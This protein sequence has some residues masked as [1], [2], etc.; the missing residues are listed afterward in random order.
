MKLV[1]LCLAVLAA[2]PIWAEE[3]PRAGLLGLWG[4][5]AHCSGTLLAP[6]GTVRAEPFEVLPGA[7]RHGALWCRLAWYPVVARGDGLFVSARAA[8]GEDA[9]RGYRLDFVLTGDRLTLI[10]DEKL[11]NGP[12]SRCAPRS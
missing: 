2:G 6:G 4:T 3:D 7:L 1:L 5:P 11:L 12:L 10:W 9:P 8:C